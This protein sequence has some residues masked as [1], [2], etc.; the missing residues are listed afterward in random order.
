MFPTSATAGWRDT[1]A[2]CQELEA[3]ISL[4]LDT[5]TLISEKEVNNV[6]FTKITQVCA[7]SFAWSLPTLW[8]GVSTC[9]TQQGPAVR[10][11][12][13]RA[14]LGKNSYLSSC[15][16]GCRLPAIVM[17]K[18]VPFSPASQWWKA[19]W[20]KTYPLSTQ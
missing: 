3:S 12:E 10:L 13:T 17:R 20:A 4:P 2:H 5:P 19:P 6:D 7:A 15:T 16:K 9:S 1:P 11:H 8:H 18:F 14:K